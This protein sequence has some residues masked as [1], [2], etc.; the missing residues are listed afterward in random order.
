[1][2]NDNSVY[3]V[4]LEWLT[5]CPCLVD[6]ELT[7]VS[8]LWGFRRNIDLCVLRLVHLTANRRLLFSRLIFKFEMPNISK[9]EL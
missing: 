5:L 4:S 7:R 3:S 9:A 1:M 8:V 2:I 6:K